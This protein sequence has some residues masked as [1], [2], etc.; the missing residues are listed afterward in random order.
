LSSFAPAYR[1]FHPRFGYLFNSYYEAL[2]PRHP[3]PQRALL[4]RP[5]VG[6]VY[7]Y[8]AHVDAAMQRLLLLGA[9]L[10]SDTPDLIRLG[11][12]HEQQHQEL[13]LPDLKAAFA[14]NPLFP[15]YAPPPAA[16]PLAVT[17][18]GPV[19]WVEFGEGVHEIGHAGPGFA[20]DNESP[21]H[22]VYLNCF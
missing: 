8:R 11:L 14:L 6:E 1:P 13:I 9:D 18:A 21:R 2:G 4:S 22:K 20:F 19:G 5:T 3:R 10:P 17:A 7:Q 16:E 12:A 15:A